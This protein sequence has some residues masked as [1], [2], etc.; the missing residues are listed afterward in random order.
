MDIYRLR[1]FVAVARYGHLT[2]ASQAVHLSQPTVS[3]QIKA[4]EDELGVALFERTP[5]GMLL[6]AWGKKVLSTANTVLTAI[7]TLVE[8]AQADS[9]KSSSKIR[10]GTIIHPTFL[11]LGEISVA[12]RKER[13]ETELELH[14]SLS[15]AILNAVQKRELDAGFFMG[16]PKRSGIGAVPLRQVGFCVIGP[17]KW[18]A[19]PHRIDTGELSRLPWIIQP[20]SGAYRQ[21][22]MRLFR[23]YGID[24]ARVIEADRE[25]TL[26]DLVA[27][28]LG[29]SLIREE[30]LS[31]DVLDKQGM[32]R[33][34]ATIATDLYFIYLSARQNDPAMQA[35][36]RAVRKVW[37]AG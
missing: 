27:S 11:R 4:L 30:A 16:A 6:T 22:S 13:P 20:R 33:L 18:I 29:L 10:I 2:R 3:G 36:I 31:A 12:T 8:Q 21:L 23:K 37:Q 15:G 35:L 28:G 32:V 14:H 9:R 17:A 26:I 24:P 25:S 34:D 7:D 5:H 1:T 19:D